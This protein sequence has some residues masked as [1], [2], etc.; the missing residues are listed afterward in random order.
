MKITKNQSS[1][2]Q[3]RVT[4]TYS[5]ESDD[6]SGALAALID[7]GGLGRL[8]H[9]LGNGETI[10]HLPESAADMAEVLHTVRDAHAALETRLRLLMTAARARHRDGFP[11]KSLGEH[12]GM[13]TMT[14]R[15]RLRDDRGRWP[16]LAPETGNEVEVIL[17][18]GDQA[19]LVTP[20]HP[21]SAPLQIPAA[22]IAQQAGIAASELPGRRFSV[23]RLTATEADGF[24]LL[25]DPRL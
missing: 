21:A 18:I 3:Q 22:R 10:D 9:E 1:D 15:R 7:S 12:A 24:T 17:T 4:V 13:A 20:R 5:P 14:A 6:P 23:D 8:L 16:D 2:D 25:N 19:E 11:L